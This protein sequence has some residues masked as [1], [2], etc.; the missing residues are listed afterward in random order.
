MH[1]D[2]DW[3][4]T[5]LG[6]SVSHKNRQKGKNVGVAMLNKEGMTAVVRFDAGAV[7]LDVQ[8]I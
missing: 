2:Q 8:S 3:E 6:L 4:L 7:G 1:G 5:A